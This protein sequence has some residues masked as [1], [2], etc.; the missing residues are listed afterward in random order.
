MAVPIPPPVKGVF[1]PVIELKFEHTVAQAAGEE[2]L[3]S[4]YELP[5]DEVIEVIRLELIPPVDAAAEVI[6]KLRYITLM[7]GGKEYDALRINSVMAPLQHQLN[8]GVAVDFGVPYLHRPLTGRIPTPIEGTCPK[9]RR[10]ETLGLKTVA[11][12]AIAA[13]QPYTIV[14][15]CARVREEAML[16]S[17]VGMAAIPVSITL[18]TDVYTKTAVPVD[19]K[20]FDQLPGGLRQTIPQ[21]F[22][23]FTYAKNKAATTP[24]TWYDFT[25][26]AYAAYPWMEL[27]WNLVNKE[28]AYI[29][30]SL[31]IIPHDNSK[32][33]RLF[34][35]GRVTNPEYVTRPLPEQN[36]FPVAQY[37]DVTV[38]RKVKLAGPRALPRP[39]LFHGVKGAIQIRDNGTSIPADG[40]E[41]HVYGKKIVL[42]GE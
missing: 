13:D 27:S 11:D 15:K 22:P 31:G 36:Y 42:K 3:S 33:A 37:Y 19:M 5:P 6:K 38:N 39:W 14:L 26:D 20:T 35:E 34:I 12:E 1:D 29:V 2:W 21:I 4:L 9:V 8:V 16:R 23:W 40:I 10:G 25:Y 28:E 24:N 32:D 17:V 7:I 30:E 18:D 41:L